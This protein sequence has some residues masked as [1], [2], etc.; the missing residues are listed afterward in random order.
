MLWSKRPT[1]RVR[2]EREHWVTL[3]GVN[4]KWWRD[5]VLVEISETGAR[6]RVDGSPDVLKSRHFFLLLSRTG[7][8]FRRCELVRLDGPEADVQFVVRSTAGL[9]TPSVGGM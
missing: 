2:F 3:L 5:C 8:A 9:S 4:G 6:L 7:L 1:K